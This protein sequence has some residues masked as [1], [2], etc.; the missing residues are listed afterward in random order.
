MYLATSDWTCESHH[1]R[2]RNEKL[3]V[4]APHTFNALSAPRALYS[5]V[6][7]GAAQRDPAEGLRYYDCT[8]ESLGPASLHQS[9]VYY[10]RGATKSSGPGIEND[11]GCW[12][13][14]L[15]FRGE[16]L[17]WGPLIRSRC[18]P[19]SRIVGTCMDILPSAMELTLISKPRT[20]MRQ[21]LHAMK[22]HTSRNKYSVKYT[23]N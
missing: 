18:H 14:C 7:S 11:A 4:V 10:I 20:S 12:L 2:T 21:A 22:G 16:D 15:R 19:V 5:S 9:G 17:R 23:S 13:T 6:A 8:P 3:K 1:V